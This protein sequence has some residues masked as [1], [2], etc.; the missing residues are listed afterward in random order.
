MEWVIRRW[1]SM[2]LC[3]E[4]SDDIGS[5]IR[6]LAYSSIDQIAPEVI[7]APRIISASLEHPQVRTV[8]AA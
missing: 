4:D 8:V 7:L 1:E 3:Y 2:W 6:I 5:S